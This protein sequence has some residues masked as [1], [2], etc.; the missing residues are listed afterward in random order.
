MLFRSVWGGL[1]LYRSLSERAATPATPPAAAVVP[2]PPIA[3]TPVL[4]WNGLG[5]DGVAAEAARQMMIAKYPIIS[6]G[7]APDSS[8]MHTY[9]MYQQKDAAGPA[10]ARDDDEGEFVILHARYGTEANHADVTDRLRELARRDR[11]FRL[12]NDEIGRAHV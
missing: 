8:Y 10:A 4:V 1:A 2:A 7:N 9:V 11:S 6:V 5:E 3:K 12:E